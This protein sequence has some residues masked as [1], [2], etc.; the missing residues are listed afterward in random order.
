VVE[1]RD[2]RIHALQ[3]RARKIRTMH[4]HAVQHGIVHARIGRLAGVEDAVREPGSGQAGAVEAAV[5]EHAA[6]EVGAREVGAR[7]VALREQSAREI[8]SAQIEPAQRT[9]PDFLSALDHGLESARR[10]AA[11]SSDLRRGTVLTCSV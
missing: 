11:F 9:L 8:E 3:A 10:H 1:A 5:V 2:A 4:H 7:E 6:F